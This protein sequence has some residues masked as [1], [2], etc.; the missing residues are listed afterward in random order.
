M[1]LVKQSVLTICILLF[2]IKTAIAQT[3]LPGI[4]AYS[5]GILSIPCIKVT[6][7]DTITDSPALTTYQVEMTYQ[8]DLFELAVANEIKIYSNCDAT[9]DVESSILKDVVQVENDIIE[10]ILHRIQD[11]KFRL[12]RALFVTDHRQLPIVLEVGK[13]R[14]LVLPDEIDSSSARLLFAN[15]SPVP[16]RIRIDRSSPDRNILLFSPIPSDEGFH[17][18]R[19]EWDDQVAYYILH[20][21]VEGLVDLSGD[22]VGETE[23]ADFS[24]DFSLDE[25]GDILSGFGLFVDARNETKFASL[26]SSSGI[27][28][29]DSNVVSFEWDSFTQYGSYRFDGVY[30]GDNK[31]IGTISNPGTA[32][33][34]FTLT[35]TDEVQL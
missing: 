17:D 13:I 9:F 14:G 11:T 20:F 32:P 35:R 26:F 30:N 1:R 33:F 10:V 19:I 8:D 31:I 15:G 5:D 22:Y 3:A 6:S 12:Y 21:Y 2:V 7:I 25:K 27:F 23:N 4:S 24:L 16:D 28:N 18:L 29:E 34:P